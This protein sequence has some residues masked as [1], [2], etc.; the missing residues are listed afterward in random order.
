MIYL[1]INR[2]NSTQICWWMTERRASTAEGGAEACASAESI[3]SF[4]SDATSAITEIY[5]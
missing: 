3:A 4:D 2:I 5:K 1:I